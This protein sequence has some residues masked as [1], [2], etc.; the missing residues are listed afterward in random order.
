LQQQLLPF[1][2]TFNVELAVAQE[3]E[4]EELQQ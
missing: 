3:Q 2:F 4:S 1:F